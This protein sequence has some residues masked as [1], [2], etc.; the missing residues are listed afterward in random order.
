MNTTTT[1]S[2]SVKKKMKN[3]IRFSDEQIR[4]LETMFDSETKIEPKKKIQVARELGLHPRQIAIW[5]QNKR[6]RW[7]SKLLERDYSILKANYN[8]LASRFEV[9]KKENQSLIVQLQKMKD[10]QEKA[11]NSISG[12]DGK[13][14][15]ANGDNIKNEVEAAELKQNLS[16]KH[17]FSDDENNTRSAAD[18]F[19]RLDEDV[20]LFKMVEAADSS[21]TSPEDWGSL[22]SEEFLNPPT[23]SYQW[24]DFWS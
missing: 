20:E 22:D 15:I 19:D 1:T 9:L 12:H 17:V 24:W 3:K 11:E 23:T 10:I 13:S 16:E 6:A 18:Y 7:K 8:N 4:C 14:D 2:S 5:F 21:L